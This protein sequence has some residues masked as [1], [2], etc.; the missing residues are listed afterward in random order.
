MITREVA[1]QQT[2]GSAEQ[3]KT[4]HTG[5]HRQQSHYGTIQLH[6]WVANCRHEWEVLLECCDFLLALHR[7]KDPQSE[8]SLHRI[9]WHIRMAKK[10]KVYISLFHTSVATRSGAACSSTPADT[11]ENTLVSLKILRYLNKERDKRSALQKRA[12]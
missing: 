12:G 7:S 4:Q 5:S 6:T 11:P 10:A 3:H 2:I 1:K 8:N 9:D